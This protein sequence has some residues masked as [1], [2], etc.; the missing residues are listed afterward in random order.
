MADQPFILKTEA[1][2]AKR[3]RFSSR[4]SDS[5]F[6]VALFFFFLAIFGSGGVFA[7]RYFANQRIAGLEDERE[8]LESELRPNLIDQVLE[9][10]R[11]LEAARAV[12]GKHVF[13][14][15][16]FEFLESATLPQVRYTSF[17]Y[18][19]DARRVD[20][21]AEAASYATLAR[22]IRVLEARK[23]VAKVDFG[24]LSL[25]DRGL[26]NFKIS[27]IFQEDLFHRRPQASPPSGG[28]AT[29]SPASSSVS[30]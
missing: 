4:M 23:E 26:V 22:Q 16:I 25:S 1:A 27:V 14:S 12:I 28:T 30:P 21:N 5:L 9:L 6:L 15:N 29:S 18:S 8:K 7:F 20:L 13:S 10:S 3:T 19:L 17:G 24:G 2:P 11:R